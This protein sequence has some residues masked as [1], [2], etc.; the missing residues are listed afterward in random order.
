MAEW[1][2]NFARIC[3]DYKTYTEPDDWTKFREDALKE[4]DEVIDW[5]HRYGIHINLDLHRSPVC[6]IQNKEPGYSQEF[7]KESESLWESGEAL[8]VCAKHWAHLAHRY[9]GIPNEELSFNLMNEPRAIPVETYVRVVKRLVEAIREEDPDR[10]I[11]ADGLRWAQVPV[12]E[13]AD[14]KIAQSTHC[15]DPITLCFYGAEWVKGAS[16]FPEP[17][18]PLGLWDKDRLQRERIKPWKELE[19]RGVG[20]HVG[21]FGTW[22]KVPHQVAL[23][24]MRDCLALWKEAGWGWALWNF[25]GPFGI[26]DSGRSDVLYEDWHYHLLDRTMLELLQSY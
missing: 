13:L 11:I 3:L 25:R 12:F 1:G 17:T 2:F 5:G 10:L 18:W 8:D 26:L 7:L 4:I 21:E 19:A 23:A 16:D 6:H 22:N 9:K 14:L 24:W 15:Y 20:V